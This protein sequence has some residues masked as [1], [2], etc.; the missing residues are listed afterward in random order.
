MLWKHRTPEAPARLDPG[1][2]LRASRASWAAREL[3]WT[4]R[5]HRGADFPAL[6]LLLA[7]VSRL[8]D[9]LLWYAGMAVLPLVAGARGWAC[10]LRMMVLGLLNLTIYLLLKRWASRPRPYVA[11]Q[12]IRACVRALDQF[13]FPSGHT[14][15]AVAFSIVLIEYFPGTAWVLVPFTLLVAL[16]RVVLGLHYPS[17]VLAGA[18]IGALMAFGVLALF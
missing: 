5:L 18:G 7:V 6:V 17:D 2:L 11:C 9:G 15:H 13:S 8:G 3:S 1:L 14:L 4:R 16:S 10:S 12:D